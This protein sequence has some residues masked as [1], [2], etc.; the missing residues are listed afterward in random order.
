MDILP[1]LNEPKNA[2]MPIIYLMRDPVLTPTINT[3]TGKAV[4]INIATYSFHLKTGPA[5]QWHSVDDD[6][7]FCMKVSAHVTGLTKTTNQQQLHSKLMNHI[8]HIRDYMKK[9]NLNQLHHSKWMEQ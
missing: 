8:S 7:E 6:Y 4:A 3:T 1:I 2:L 9:H 5:Y